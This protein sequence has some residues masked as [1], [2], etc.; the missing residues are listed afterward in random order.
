MKNSS[1]IGISLII[2]IFGIIFV[3]RILDKVGSGSVVEADR[4]NVAGKKAPKAELTYI[5]QYGD[6]KKIQD[7]SFINQNGDT[8][9]NKDYL[10]KVYVVEFFFTT[11]PDICPVM[12]KNLVGVQEEFKGNEDF[13]IISITIDPKHDTPEVLKNYAENYG[14]TSPNWNFLTG[15]REEIYDLANNGFGIFASSDAS[16][17][18]GFAHSG[19]FALID[20]EGYVRSRM[21]GFGNP[22]YAYRGS[23]ER[24][25]SFVEGEEE[26]Q[27]E[28]L[29]EDIKQLL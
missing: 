16:G 3:P 18:G 25:K 2:L 12:N 19:L 20:K 26:P 21:D 8:I 9:T 6:K 10:G 1:Y 29:I 13:G 17:S 23:I 15:D 11:C 14:V 4:L 28:I 5:E 7:F 22:I 24:K 27:I